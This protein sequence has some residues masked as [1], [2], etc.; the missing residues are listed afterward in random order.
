MQNLD[1]YSNDE[2]LYINT[3]DVLGDWI[4]FDF[5][6]I[7]KSLEKSEIRKIDKN[8]SGGSEPPEFEFDKKKYSEIVTFGFEDSKG[9][10]GCYD[11]MDFVSAKLFLQVIKEKLLQYKYC[12]AWGSK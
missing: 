11:V 1:R 4:A 2:K 10:K 5:E 12:F 9:N 8:A 3:K 6:W 7:N